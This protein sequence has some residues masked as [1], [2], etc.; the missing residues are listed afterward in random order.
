MKR[1]S[2]LL[3]L[4]LLLLPVSPALGASFPDVGVSHWAGGAIGYLSGQNL[5]GGFPDGTFQPGGPLTR[6]QAASIVASWQ[7]LDPDTAAFSDVPGT[8]WAAGA[9]GAVSAAGLM[10]GYPDGTFRPA[11]TLTRA[12]AAVVLSSAFTPGTGGPTGGFPDVPGGHW[13][14]GAIGALQEGFVIGGFP[15]GTFRPGAPVTRAEFSVLLARAMNPA[16]LQ[17]AVLTARATQAVQLLMASDLSGLSAMVHPTDGVRISPYNY[18]LPSHLVFFPQDLP[19]LLTDPT[20]Y[21]WGTE[22]GT[23]DPILRTAQSYFPRYLTDRDYT[24]PDQVVYN[25]IIPRGNMLY[26]LDTFWPNGV[27]VEFFVEGTAQYGQMDWR[28][29]FVVLTEDNGT[30]YVT[31]LVHGEWTT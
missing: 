29:L 8:H 5:I 31:G 22:D 14:A 3:I 25:Q 6:A 19:G 26:N 10:N 30:W 15:D 12:E 23:G 21:H 28:S 27:F 2:V 18:V 20:V 9:I 24:Q 4:S 17:P 7:G 16:F 13:A 11:R 1:V